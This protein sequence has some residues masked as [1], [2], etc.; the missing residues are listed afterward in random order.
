[1]PIA[2][3]YAYLRIRDEESGGGS[4]PLGLGLGI[5]AAAIIVFEMLLWVRKRLRGYR[6]G[7]TRTWM[8]WHIWLGLLSLPLAVCHT[9]FRLGGPLPAALLIVFLVVIASG[10]W[11]LVLQQ[12]LPQ[13]LL[14]G[15]ATEAVESE[16]DR[17]MEHHLRE[18][19]GQVEAVSREGDPLR[20]L[21]REEIEPYLTGQPRP[22]LA[23]A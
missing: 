16:I 10:V 5:A 15:F 14:D 13:R 1:M 23:S 19:R 4:S 9:G 12:T 6:L 22:A 3:W 2:G 21:M 8:F 7:A 18:L 17:V 11:G 20:R